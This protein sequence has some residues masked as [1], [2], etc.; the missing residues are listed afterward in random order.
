MRRR[1]QLSGTADTDLGRHPVAGRHPGSFRS[2]QKS[3]IL[4]SADLVGKLT[5]EPDSEW[6]EWRSGKPI[7]QAQL[8]RLLRPFGVAP[9]PGADQAISRVR[10]YRRQFEMLGRYRWKGTFRSK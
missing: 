2:K 1:K 10:G 3:A 7:T 5:A 4:S 9:C 6:A 8:A